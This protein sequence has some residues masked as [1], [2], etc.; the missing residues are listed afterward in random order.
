MR[1]MSEQRSTVVVVG[2]GYAGTMAANRLAAESSFDVVM[3]N[4]RDHF[5]ER[6]RLHQ[7]AAG[8]ATPTRDFQTLLS[9]RV[10]R[11]VATAEHIDA[12]GRLVGLDSGDRLDYD[13]LI[14]AV[15]SSGRAAIEGAADHAQQVTNWESAT[16]L[17]NRLAELRGAGRVT[18][19]GGGLTGIE[20]A[21]ELAEAG[22]RVTLVTADE[23]ASSLSVR[24]RE[25]TR[26]ALKHLGVVC[27]EHTRVERIGATT[28]TLVH[29]TG[30]W[31][32]AA[33]DIT[34]VTTGFAVPDLARR[35]GLTCDHLGRLCTDAALV[36]VDDER[37]LGAGDAVAPA[38][39]V[40]R[41]SCQAAMPLGLAA[42]Q[43]VRA[44][45]KGEHPVAAYPGFVAQCVS[46]GRHAATLQLTHK[47]DSPTRG[48]VTGRG[49]ALMKELICRGTIWG[50]Q[51]EA[52]HPGIYPAARSTASVDHRDPTPNGQ[53]VP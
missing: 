41:M 39:N 40:P 25:R 47:D 3:V 15:G 5:V 11:I 51:L 32:E 44:L 13:W 52:R 17:R 9:A 7:W 34:V 48:V 19:V 35:S 26:R 36:S 22:H 30:E 27:H 14:Y 42:A 29:A 12:P 20:T 2:G 50:L 33:T 23:I 49:A 8:T 45:A 31:V 53:V 18:V 38:G 24:G 6:I 16:R 37:I 21:A 1:T 43:S 28:V 10:R 4:A 46:L